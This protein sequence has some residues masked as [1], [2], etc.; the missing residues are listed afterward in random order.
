MRLETAPCK[1]TREKERGKSDAGE[2]IIL[3]DGLIGPTYIYER[4]GPVTKT[5]QLQLSISGD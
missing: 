1:K 3:I 5:T 2:K 4:D